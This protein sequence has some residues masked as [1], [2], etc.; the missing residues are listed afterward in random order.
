MSL[1]LNTSCDSHQHRLAES[2]SQLISTSISNQKVNSIVEDAS[3]YIWFGTFRGVN[4]YNGNDFHQY[5]N[6][7]DST[8]VADNQIQAIYKDSRKRL[9]IATV[10]GVSLY[11]ENGTF[12][13]APIESKSRNAIQILENKEGRIFANMIFQLCAYDPDKK[14]FTVVIDHFFDNVSFINY[15]HIDKA[16]R[17]WSITPFLIRSFNSSTLKLLY[18]VK[19]NKPIHY[20]FLRDNG[21]LWLASLNTLSIFNTNSGKF[22]SIPPAISQHPVLSKSIITLIHAYDN[23][24]L[25]INTQKDGLFLYNSNT[26]KV[27]RQNESGFP[28]EAPTFEIKSMFTDSKKNLWIGSTDQGFAVRYNYK[29]RFNNNNYL[30]TYFEKKS[31]SAVC[32]DKN[33][34]LWIATTQHGI[35][36]YNSNIQKVV[37][38]NTTSFFPEIK[39]YKDRINHLF[40]DVNNN[41]WLLTNTK[42]LKCRYSN[43]T[44][45]CLE[46]F[47]FFNGLMDITQDHNGTIWVGGSGEWV[48]A[49][50][51]D[52]KTFRKIQLYPK[53]FNFT[54]K[55]LTLASGD[56]LV[57]S[58]NQNLKLINPADM[59]VKEIEV[60]KYMKRS[61]F[62]PIDLYEDSEGYV[63]IATLTNGLLRYSPK[64]H[65]MESMTGIPCNDASSIMEDVQGNMWIGTLFGLCKFDKTVQRFTAYYASDGIG[66]NQF[67]E[68]SVCILP[69]HTLILGGTHG[70]TF[71]NPLDVNFKRQI[72]LLFEDLKIHNHLVRPSDEKCIDKELLYRPNIH[73]NYNENS[74]SIS[75]SAIDYGEYTRV[76]YFYKLDGFDKQWIDA[77]NDRSAYYSNVPS[78]NYVF[79]LRITNNDNTNVETETSIPVS[80]ST[81]PWLS[82]PALLLYAAMVVALVWFISYLYFHINI[83]RAR[84]LMAIAEK[85]QEQRVNQMN[86]SFFSNISHEFRTPL[87]MISGPVATLCKDE[88]IRGESKTLLVT[89][90]RS[91]NR[92][93]RL[94]N[95]LMDFNKLEND[96]LRLYVRKKDVVEQINQFLETF[97]VNAKEKGVAL[98]TY[99]LEESYNMWIDTDKLEKI[100]SNLISNALKFTSQG[101]KIDIWFDV[102]PRDEAEKFFPLTSKD[103]DKEYVKMAIEDTGRGVPEDKLEKIFER[104]Y[105]VQHQTKEFYNWGSGIG[106]YYARRLAELHHGYIKAEN[107]TEGQGT[108]MSF[109]LPI[110]KMSY[111]DDER[112]TDEEKDIYYTLPQPYEEPETPNKELEDE[113]P[114][115]L[116]IDDDTDIAHYLKTLFSSRYRVVVKF[117]ADSAYKSIEEV[118]PDL[119]VSDVLMPGIDGYQFCRMVKENI[120]YSHIPVILLTAKATVENQVEGL[121]TG[122]NAYVTKPFEPQYLMALIKSQLLNREQTRTILS[123]STQTEKIDES[124]LSPQD[125]A[126]MSTLYKLMESELSNSELNITQLTEALK[127]S[128]TKFYYKV[129]GLTGENPNVFFKTYKLNRAVELILDGK[130]NT[131]EIAD[132]TG[133]STLSH[134]SA[135]FKKQFGVSPSKYKRQ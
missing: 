62:I 76:R 32:P 133:F 3:G 12:F 31:V 123:S 18:S 47:P 13:T 130:H 39:F 24:S 9:W 67:N 73:L 70:L 85:E 48:F 77:H 119:I 7:E 71:F 64:N 43:G 23:V 56:I 58:F 40:V 115:L 100:L 52:E 112:K 45:Q 35:F 55:I 5:F 102:I 51:R 68:R 132:M 65:K 11:N 106:L 29:K 42:L 57:G 96:T 134:F 105:Q 84:A 116:I 97:R 89:V 2:D 36:M 111:S 38:V 101:G 110:N 74:F 50:R 41:I 124:V 54:A 87:T 53:G 86:M 78:G 81:P 94:I 127:I 14:K 79:K 21:E 95:Q 75:Y 126:F 122:A 59:S 49:L 22:T 66:G 83:N 120:S 72:P 90:Q 46:T 93:L 34:N 4:R 16:D 69:D 128:R 28:F 27:I 26:E 1:L 80:I 103:V 131:S 30:Q 25:L 117:D 63:W 129:K 10:N 109:I 98:N 107:R 113:K 37:A 19:S 114:T 135:S 60:K 91:V 44:L 6:T 61:V 118:M 20:S 125:N 88:D 33:K 82:W 99:G 104:Y 8:S 15:C 108:I 92:M 121:N 17:L